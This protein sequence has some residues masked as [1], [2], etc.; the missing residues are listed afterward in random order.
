MRWNGSTGDASGLGGRTRLLAPP[1]NRQRSERTLLPRRR[2]GA[3]PHSRRVV[4]FASVAGM[5]RHRPGPCLCARHSERSVP[6]LFLGNHAVCD[7]RVGTR[8]EESLSRVALEEHVSIYPKRRMIPQFLI[9][10]WRLETA[11]TRSKHTMTHH[12]NRHVCGTLR[13]RLWRWKL[14]SKN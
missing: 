5:P 4:I 2:N 13:E 10:I 3:L 1:I 11:V 8:S 9:D 6:M 7:F 14:Q 12:S